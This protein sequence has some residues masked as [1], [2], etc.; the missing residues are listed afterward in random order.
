MRAVLVSSTS[1]K[2]MGHAA[3][4]RD[5]NLPIQDDLAPERQQLVERSAEQGRA[6]VS[7]AG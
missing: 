4:V 1:T 2:T 6:I 5:R 7:P 3:I